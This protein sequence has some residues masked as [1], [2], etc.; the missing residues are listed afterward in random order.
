MT[1]VWIVLGSLSALCAVLL[2]VT[3][4]I[5]RTAFF[6]SLRRP[7]PYRLHLS[8]EYTPWRE[9]FTGWIRALDDRPYESVR[10]C[11]THD[12]TPLFARYFH[13]R[14]G[15]PLAI[16]M[17]GY[18][19]SSVRDFCGGAPLSMDRFGHNVLLVDQRAHGQSGGHTIT[20]GIL[21]QYDCRDWVRYACERFG[22]DTPIMLYGISMGGA[23]VLTASDLDLCESVRGIVADCPYTTPTDIIRKTCREMKLP[24]KICFPLIRLAAR[25]FGGFSLS[26]DGP[27]PLLSVSRTHLPILLIHGEA[28]TFVPCDMSLRIKQVGGDRVRLETFPGAVHAGSYLLDADRYCRIIYEFLCDCGLDCDKNDPSQKGTI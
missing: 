6:S 5:Y 19:S 8:E 26:D 9:Q 22:K 13:V 27:H 11:S 24:A 14:D 21:E 12:G 16:Q 7:D 20:F 15:A 10:I 2:T 28:D 17:H 1:A 25:L 18:R 4:L 23:T 3:Y